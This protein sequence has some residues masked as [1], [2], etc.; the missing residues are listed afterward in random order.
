MGQRRDRTV[1]VLLAVLAT[2]VQFVGV[3]AGRPAQPPDALAGVLGGVLVSAA[4]LAQ[5]APL[6]WR[7][8]RP[9]AVFV[10]CL[11]GYA[12][13]S[14]V[15][16]GVPPVAGWLALY[17]VGVYARPAR[18]A[19]YAL[20]VGA[21]GLVAVIV[22]GALVYP[23][24]I[25][26][27]VLLGLVTVIVVL[28]ATIVHARQA[29]LDALRERAA[30]LEREREAA[31][32]QAAAE[33]RLRIARDVHDLVGHGLS[34]IAVQSST[35][36]LALD[37]GQLEQARD[38]LAAVEAGSRDA[39]A[40]MRQLLGLLR[41]DDTSGYGPAPGL[42]DLPG[43]VDRLRAQGTSVSLSTN[44]LGDLPEAAS[45]AGY[46]IA[47]EA[48]TNAIK[49]APGSR[50]TVDINASGG[51]LIVVV[52]D[53]AGRA[54]SPRSPQPAGGHGLVGMRER[55][56]AFGGEVSAGPAG[57]HPGW[58]VRAVIPYRREGPQ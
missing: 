12:V 8:R 16:P 52:D 57:D 44:G 21:G 58:R 18:R 28:L 40:E 54:A 32:A 15:V 4:A 37:A 19:A 23:A 49:H 27:L 38:A 13:N 2:V 36:R 22:A 43:L 41:G 26:E 1:D 48:L 5:G 47:Q 9:V 45:L 39:L 20:T 34:G 25:P 53:D 17:A 56:A 30:A 11:V 33:E 31:V 55:V 7:R 6:V 42:R 50:V 24:T 29:Q 51:A 10:V 3:R 46:R 35:A 14:V